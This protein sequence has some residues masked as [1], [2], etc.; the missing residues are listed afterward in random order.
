MA[1]FTL[2][3][4]NMLYIKLLDGNVRRQCHL[5]LGPLY[6]TAVLREHGIEVDFRDYQLLEEDELFAPETLCSFLRDPAPIIGISCMANLIPFVLYA[7]PLLKERYPDRTI[8]LGG[9][10][11][12]FIEK[13]ILER[14]PE[15]DII[16]RGEGERTVPALIEALREGRP[17]DAIPGLF[18]RR[19]GTVIQNPPVSRITDLDGLP[20]PSYDGLD[21]KRYI[22]HN[23]LGS[24]GCPYPCTF[25]SI[26]P[27]WGWKAYSR[28]NQNIIDEMSLMYHEHGVRQFLFQDEYFVSSPERMID[29][30][31]LLKKSGMDVT[32]KIFARVNLVNEESLKAMAD[33]GCVEI[34]FGIESGS[35]RILQLIRKG[36]D[37]HSAL[38]T[39]SLAKK[40]IDSVDT[41]YIWG[42]PFETK[43]DMGDSIFQMITFRGMGVRPLP[44]LLTYLPQTQIY[45][46]IEDKSKLEFCHYLLPEYMIS[47]IEK[48]ISVRIA[49]DD[50]YAE[51]FRFVEENRDIFPGF[52]QFDIENNIL[53][54]LGMLEEFEFYRCQEEDSCGAHSPSM[55]EKHIPLNI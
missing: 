42:Y 18:Y 26:T 6:L 43:E 21:F 9:V 52:F 35:D 44:S 37:S 7:M 33:S 34:R 29:F 55:T 1:D 27:L 2:V 49:I 39:V 40:H 15:V 4:M 54:K 51:L 19:N 53:P 47:G 12:A 45:H 13:E 10:G 24:R 23:I 25:C 16:H 46:D 11:T 36:F 14:I 30:S 3:N 41:F 8:I 17:L 31:R 48:R 22:G 38:K 5:P 28:S 32:Y 50:R 20:R